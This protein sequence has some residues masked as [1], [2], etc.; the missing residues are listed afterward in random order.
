[1]G[2]A[3][4]AGIDEVD[5]EAELEGQAEGLAVALADEDCEDVGV[6]VKT[7]L[8]KRKNKN[9]RKTLVLN[10]RRIIFYQVFA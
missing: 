10:N 2:E 9:E 3:E 6:F 5:T 8:G 1:M 4:A 7:D